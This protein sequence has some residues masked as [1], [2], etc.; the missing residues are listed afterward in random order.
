[1]TLT[2][3]NMSENMFM[4]SISVEMPFTTL[5]I[6]LT[7]SAVRTYMLFWLSAHESS[8]SGNV[9]LSFGSLS[10]GKSLRL[11]SGRIY[12]KKGRA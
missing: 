2:H 8:L 1:M 10:C 7:F 11:F 9:I 4:P 6:S 12:A 3:L 5:L